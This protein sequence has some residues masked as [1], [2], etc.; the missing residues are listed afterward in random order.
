MAPYA[1]FCFGLYGGSC[2]PGL[3]ASDALAE[4]FFLRHG[5]PIQETRLVFQRSLTQPTS[6]ADARFPAL[7]R[8]YELRVTPRSG[9]STW[10]QESVLGPVEPVEFRLED[11][12]TGCL[13]AS[14]AV[15]E[16]DGFS[17]RWN[18]PAIG[19]L[20]LEVHEDLRRRGL[21]KFLITQLLH[22]LQDQFFGLVEVQIPENNE[23]AIKLIRAVGFEQVDVGRRYKKA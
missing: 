11:K 4:P 6:S 8:Q 21:A 7:R 5:Y 3:L 18:Q 15:W 14:A 12:A 9:V 1:P 22:Y 20:D 13:A 16:M 23:A 10:W 2:L 17:W 19:I